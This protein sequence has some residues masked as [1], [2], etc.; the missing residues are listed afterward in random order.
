MG[1]IRSHGFSR[2]RIGT[3]AGAFQVLRMAVR[4]LGNFYGQQDT[5][6]IQFFYT[7]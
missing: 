2:F 1:K 5:W 4:L 3:L 7:L 6:P